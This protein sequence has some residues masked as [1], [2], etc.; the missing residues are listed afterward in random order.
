MNKYERNIKQI[1]D[2]G[3]SAEMYFLDKTKQE[4]V[5]LYEEVEILKYN[6]SRDKRIRE[7]LYSEIA[8][9]LNCIEYLTILFNLDRDKIE[10][11]RNYKI[12]RGYERGKV[13]DE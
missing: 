8:D 12:D 11:I 7:N 1:K 10:N 4:L 6:F 3:E 13:A 9:V 2:K 5:E